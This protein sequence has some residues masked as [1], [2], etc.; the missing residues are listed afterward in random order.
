[1]GTTVKK[2]V[3][4]ATLS[5]VIASSM[6]AC[7]N[8]NAP[9]NYKDEFPSLGANNNAKLVK[10]ASDYGITKRPNVVFIL[11]DDAGYGDISC[12]GQ[13]NFKT[14]N[15]DLL[16]Q[17]GVRFVNHY[18][19]APVCAPSRCGLMTGKTT[20]HTIIRGN[21]EIGGGVGLYPATV[22]KEGQK[23]LP[24]EE[25]TL[26]ELFKDAGYNTALV[27][28]WGLGMPENGSSP[29]NKGFDR[30]YGHLCQRMAHSYFPTHVWENDKKV[31]FSENNGL[32]GN[33][34]L[35][36]QFEEKTKAYLTD[37][38]N[39]NKNSSKPFFFF[40]TYTIPH[41]ALQI[42]KGKLTDTTYHPYV[43]C[44]WWKKASDDMKRYAIMMHRVDLT[45]GKIKDQLEEAGILDDTIFIFSS[46]NGP[47][48]EYGA[49]PNFFES[50]GRFGKERLRGIKRA[51]YEGGVKV[52]FIVSW[53]NKVKKGIESTHI[54]AAYDIM[55]TM[56]QILGI[57][58]NSKTNSDG[59]SFLPTLMDDLE[60]QKIHPHLYWEFVGNRATEGG[61]PKQGAR[62]G[63][64]KAVLR[65]GA[66]NS[67]TAGKGK[68]ELYHLGADPGEKY[69]VA[70]YY[71][72]IT[73]AMRELL[74]SSHEDSSEF[75][76]IK[77]N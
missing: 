44:S 6:V 10:A 22:T 58:L 71:P 18:A 61:G 34:W 8:P 66:V 75:P 55:A 73:E 20:G 36:D 14:P 47:A 16:A 39:D 1:M 38:I 40:G 29:L 42:P 17:N 67:A 64:W 24:K 30:Y 2:N 69:N 21:A 13:I 32:Q 37:F 59:L 68:I 28:K 4:L 51:L 43:D 3:T 15:I 46:D 45:V 70:K 57:D 74:V 60:N 19:A 7:P 50:A 23:G 9:I 26:A 48:D 35:H 27:G 52:P 77:K 5:T 49:N 76:Q 25:Y 53:P 33:V 72:N 56:A 65:F 12:N 31:V 54:C 62:V 63:D 11:L 41:G